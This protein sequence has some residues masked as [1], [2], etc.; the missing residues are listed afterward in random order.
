MSKKI[1]LSISLVVL[2]MVFCG[3]IYSGETRADVEQNDTSISQNASLT[4]FLK[5][6]N[7]K[8]G[9]LITTSN[10]SSYYNY[11]ENVNAGY[12]YVEDKLADGLEFIGFNTTNDGT[13]GGRKVSSPNAVCSGNVVDD[14]HEISKTQGKWNNDHTEYTYHGLHYNANTRTV[15]FKIENLE[16]DCVITVGIKTKT[17]SLKEGETK[18]DLYNYASARINGLTVLSNLVHRYIGGDA[19][20]P[21]YVDYTYDT[22]VDINSSLLP[23]PPKTYYAPGV[24][25]Q[26]NND[27]Y[28]M[29]YHFDGWTTSDVTVTDG[30][31]E[32]PNH[33]VNFV[34]HFTPIQGHNVT[35]RIDGTIPEG[36]VV[37]S[38]KMYY[39]GA[40]VRVDSLKSGE[41]FN[42]Y[43]FQGWTVNGATTNDSNNIFEMPN[44]NI[45]I[46]GR[47]VEKKYSLNY[48]FVDRSLP[49]NA[50]SLLP[51]SQEY[52][53]GDT[54]NLAS[55]ADQG[56]YLFVGWDRSDTFVMPAN[57]VTVNG[58]WQTF[59]G[60]YEPELTLTNLYPSAYYKLGDMVHFKLHVE[61]DTGN[62]FKMGFKSDI[63]LVGA[64]DVVDDIYY[65]EIPE[66]TDITGYYFID[67]YSDLEMQFKIQ[68]I[69][70]EPLIG[71]YRYTIKSNDY[72]LSATIN[73]APKLYLCQKSVGSNGVKAGV[74]NTT[75]KIEG[76]G[77]SYDLKL[78]NEC[79]N[80][81]L[82]P[83]TYHIKESMP[84]EQRISVV[85]GLIDANDRNF[86]IDSD[87]EKEN[88]IIFMNE[89]DPSY[90][91]KTIGYRPVNLSPTCGE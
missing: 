44:Q 72:L 28:Y 35:Y 41:I 24:D 68:L 12:I 87:N 63:Y 81:Y 89:V 83:G 71:D 86:V 47:F 3:I 88:V 11:Y 18:V 84:M 75:F 46:V 29:G 74:G 62:A 60:E 61:N 30:I 70:V 26:V 19:Y 21:Y 66:D 32:M 7:S 33:N 1:K 64:S 58:Y 85:L 43:E 6:T 50:D 39:P 27:V 79:I 67:E 91:I 57:D 80:L 15:S 14:T 36:Y 56:D 90:F 76:E 78:N 59:M 5:V 54:V 38:T 37:P 13:I 34:G 31:F 48:R 82:T 23:T 52:R 9:Y 8:V 40:S 77:I 17:P 10:G 49:S 65:F 53:V 22:D 2:L 16:N 25:V 73:L 42:G 4:Y 45:E 20:S 69:Y 55:I 51:S